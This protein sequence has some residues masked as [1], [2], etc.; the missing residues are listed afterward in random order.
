[1]FILSQNKEKLYERTCSDGSADPSCEGRRLRGGSNRKHG[2]AGG[3][4]ARAE[5]RHQDQS[6]DDNETKEPDQSPGGTVVERVIRTGMLRDIGQT[7]D[8]SRKG[9]YATRAASG[10]LKEQHRDKRL[11]RS[12]QGNPGRNGGVN[13]GSRLERHG[14]TEQKQQGSGRG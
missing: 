3:R 13:N 7:V 8:R 6:A 5:R 11:Q 2:G 12:G 1:M 4:S 10:V 9:N 14:R